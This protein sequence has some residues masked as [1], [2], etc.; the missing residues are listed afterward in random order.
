MSKV[1]PFRADQVGSLLRPPE[2]KQAFRA[3]GENRISQA[4]LREVQDR[5]IRDAVALQEDVGLDSITDGEFR[6][7]SYWS[8]F[9]AAV[10]GLTIKESLFQF[11]DERGNVTDFT[12]PH[13]E[14]RVSRKHGIGTDAFGFLKQVTSRT[15]KVTMPSPSTMHFWRG[16][17]GIDASAYS[18]AEEFFAD[19]C[20][21]YRE[22]IADLAAM[23]AT[24][25]QLDEVP[26]AMLCDSQVRETMA[27]RGEDA[28]AALALYIDAL[29]VA[30]RERP[31]EMRV[32][33]HLCRGNYKGKWI[34]EGGYDAVAERLFNETNVDGF[35]LEYDTPR[36]GDF[37]PLRFVPRN[38]IVVLGLISTK[39]AQLEDKD[40]LKD[41]I[42]AAA[43]MVPLDQLAISPQCGFASTVAGNPITEADERA[44]LKLVVETAREVWR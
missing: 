9:V 7:G 2:L 12:S 43:R 38:K 40:A 3:F 28:G 19:L 35:F 33:V 29:N 17:A 6:R 32:A 15:P 18:S 42:D 22:E 16:R 34:T 4:Q 5:C 25:V 11:R 41:R 23:G 39:T 27:A 14:R 36:A 8:H 30:T 44:K 37:A 24:Y 13:V 10:D 26:I 31:A 1:P 20:R 21:V